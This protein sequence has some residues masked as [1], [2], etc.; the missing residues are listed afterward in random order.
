MGYYLSQGPVYMEKFGPGTRGTLP[1][2]RVPRANFSP[3]KQ[4]LS[5]ENAS[6]SSLVQAWLQHLL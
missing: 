3:Y 1:G 4:G 2:G 5:C 6:V